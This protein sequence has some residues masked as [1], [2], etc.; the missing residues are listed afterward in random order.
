MHHVCSQGQLIKNY[1]MYGQACVHYVHSLQSMAKH[2]MSHN[3][4]DPGHHVHHVDLCNVDLYVTSV[5]YLAKLE[6]LA[7]ERRIKSKLQ[8]QDSMEEGT[9]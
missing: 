1:L 9:G 4:L 2:T 3:L 5:R 7:E 8:L 6:R